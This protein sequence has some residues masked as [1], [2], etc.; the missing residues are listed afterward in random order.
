MNDPMDEQAFRDA[1]MKAI[2]EG[3]Y[4]DNSRMKT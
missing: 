1:I 2:Q 3:N 4:I